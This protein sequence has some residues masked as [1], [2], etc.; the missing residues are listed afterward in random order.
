MEPIKVED[1]FALELA[2]KLVGYRAVLDD[3]ALKYGLTG[4]EFWTRLHK[5]YKIDM[6]KQLYY[7]HVNKEVRER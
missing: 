7:D 4:S 3:L 6:D 2:Q 5:V 1:K